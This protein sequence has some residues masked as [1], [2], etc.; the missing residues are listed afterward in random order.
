MEMEMEMEMGIHREF[1]GTIV[2]QVTTALRV[3]AV[4]TCSTIVPSK[5]LSLLNSATV[6]NKYQHM[7]FGQ[8]SL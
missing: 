5:L 8:L 3:S 1:E 7:N 2:L 4:V 6:L